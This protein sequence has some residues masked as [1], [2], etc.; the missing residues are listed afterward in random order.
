MST[1]NEV[2][3][4]IG[5]SIVEHSPEI[6]TGFGVISG[7]AAVG[8]AIY[9]TLKLSKDLQ[10][11]PAKDK[12]DL[13]KRIALAVGPAALMEA[14]SIFLTVKGFKE[15]VDE[16]DEAKD[17]LAA[18]IVAAVSAKEATKIKEDALKKT[19]DEKTYTQYKQNEAQE[20]MDRH[21]I[22]THEITMTAQP[23]QIFYDRISD[24]YFMSTMNNV[25]KAFDKLNW[26]MRTNKCVGCNEYFWELGLKELDSH[27]YLGWLESVDGYFDFV[28]APA[29]TTDGR[30]CTAIEGIDTPDTGYWEK[31]K[32]LNR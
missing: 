6:K 21:P 4:E 5:N 23:Q 27:R 8:F 14:V 26:L 17:T 28:P 24:R 31:A 2:T 22:N 20:Q 10:E 32:L 30:T 11:N 15:V 7:L 13:A 19:L 9:G 25:N 16:R 3:Q 12:K 29:F 18:A 1:F